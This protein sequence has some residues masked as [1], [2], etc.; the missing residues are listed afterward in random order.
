MQLLKY[1]IP[2]NDRNT[3]INKYYTYMYC[4]FEL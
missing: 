4:L 2:I 3:V 1:K